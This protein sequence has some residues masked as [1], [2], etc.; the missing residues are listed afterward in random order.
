[1]SWKLE[2][3]ATGAIFYESLHRVIKKRT[4]RELNRE[5]DMVR[6]TPDKNDFN[7]C[8]WVSLMEDQVA[9]D[10]VHAVDWLGRFKADASCK[11][12][13]FIEPDDD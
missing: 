10:W 5:L 9:E 1:M 3:N 4:R 6:F 12:L 11:I 2:L 13:A 8:C 7:N